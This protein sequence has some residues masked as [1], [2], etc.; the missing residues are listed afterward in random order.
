[1]KV[2]PYIEEN[3]MVG[4]YL[5]CCPVN[6]AYCKGRENNLISDILNSVTKIPGI[7]VWQL[8][9]LYIQLKLIF[10]KVNKLSEVI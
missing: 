3:W 9:V 7:S 4:S 6:R 2:F 1:M 5:F 8:L 10:K